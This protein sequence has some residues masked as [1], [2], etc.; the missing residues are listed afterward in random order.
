MLYKF[1]SG[2]ILFGNIE[3]RYL[4]EHNSVKDYDKDGG[5]E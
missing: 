1:C 5:G 2:R 4:F 3:V